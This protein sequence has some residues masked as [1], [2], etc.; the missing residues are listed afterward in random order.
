MQRRDQR[1]VLQP[2][3]LVEREALARGEVRPTCAIAQLVVAA[4]QDV[5]PPG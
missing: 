2:I 5:R 3:A 1:Q 4:E